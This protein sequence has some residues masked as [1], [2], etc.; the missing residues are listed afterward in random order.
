MPSTSTAPSATNGKYSSR[1]RSPLAALRRTSSAFAWHTWSTRTA[2]SRRTVG[3]APSPTRAFIARRSV[4]LLWSRPWRGSSSRASAR[5]QTTA[6][7]AASSTPSSSLAPKTTTT[8]P[9]PRASPPHSLLLLLTTTTTTLT[10]LR[11]WRRRASRPRRRRGG[12]ERAQRR[13]R[14]SLVAGTSSRPPSGRW[15][16]RTTCRRGRASVR[17][18]SWRKLVLTRRRCASS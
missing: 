18:F 6:S 2:T 11:G 7:S 9:S 13:W 4:F 10:L 1:T 5:D 8:C 3:A 17:S 14:R 12:G 15:T 16:A